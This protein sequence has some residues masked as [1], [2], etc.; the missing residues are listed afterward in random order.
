MDV[1]QPG[2]FYIAGMFPRNFKPA[3]ARQIAA[4]FLLDQFIIQE[5]RKLVV[6]EQIKHYI[7]VQRASMKMFGGCSDHCACFPSR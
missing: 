7:L 5:P 3:E 6:S 4:V 1:A 2:E